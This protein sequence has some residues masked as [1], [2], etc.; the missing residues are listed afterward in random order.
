MR[1]V[2]TVA[3]ATL[4]LAGLA[5][6]G[7]AGD[8]MR[9][10]R[11]TVPADDLTAAVS[12]NH[13]FAV[14]LYQRLASSEG[15]LVCSPY[16]ISVALGMTYAGAGGETAA[17]MARVL[18][19]SLPPPRLHPALNRLDLDLASGSDET[20]TLRAANALWGQQGVTFQPA[21]LDT[22]GRNY[23]G[24]LRTVDFRADSEGARRG[25]NGWVSE[26]TEAKIP[27]LLAPGDLDDEVLL[28]LTNAIY[29][30]GKWQLP[31]EPASTRPRPFHL[32]GGESVEVP[33]MGQKAYFGY[34]DLDGVSLLELP[35][36]GGRV[37][38]LLALPDEG[39]LGPLER[40]MTGEAFGQVDQALAP[41][42]VILRLPKWRFETRLKLA[43][44]LREMGMGD[45][46]DP[47]RA[48][49]RGITTDLPFYIGEV[50]HQAMVAVDE[51]G[52]EAAAATAVVGRAGAAPP[53]TE[54]IVMTFDRPYLFFI[55]DRATGSLLF[56]GRVA[57]PR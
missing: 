42:E 50:I 39:M 14:R 18:D 44:T 22:V 36:E 41:T 12:G 10:T 51:E 46:V 25:I 56:C 5:A 24:G 13:D 31:F 7:G 35:Y 9:E 1:R 48:D 37:S 8:V 43:D 4:I 11:P 57:D 6:A 23:G 16:S 2:S 34:A 40:A 21:F 30:L 54:P 17:Q 38:M 33:F 53:Q 28:V 45:A 49:F 32:L 3:A 55:R 26:Q 19:F 52:T 20:F 47:L 29:F 27:E 15:N